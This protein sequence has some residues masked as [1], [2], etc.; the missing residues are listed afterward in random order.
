MNAIM[1][2]RSTRRYLDKPVEIEKIESILRAAMQS[3]TAH[4]AQG[5]EF[6]IV[7]N[8]EK[9]RE[10]SKM[11]P[12]SGF[13]AGAPVHIVCCTDLDRAYPGPPLWPSDMG[14]V[15]QTILI[16][17]EEEGLGACWMA[18]WPIEERS[19]YLRG[20]LGIPK[21]V[22]P[23]AVMSVGYKQVEKPFDDRFDPKKVHWE[24]F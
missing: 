6:V 14:A 20:L 24:R 13:S 21:S 12:W 1:K 7:T 9:R 19:E 11:S 15:C 18:A 10:I 22:M 23:Y 16:Q 5:W 17:A 3:P 4:N 2:R 8:E